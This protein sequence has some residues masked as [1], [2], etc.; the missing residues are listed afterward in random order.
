M[1]RDLKSLSDEELARIC[2]KMA[3]ENKLEIAGILASLAAVVLLFLAALAGAFALPFVVAVLT[4]LTVLGVHGLVGMPKRAY[5]EEL[6][7][8]RG[9]APLERYLEEARKELAQGRADWTILF[10]AHTSMRGRITW[11]RISLIEGPPAQAQAALRVSAWAL[12][13]K[14][15]EG[16]L[17]DMQVDG[18]LPDA[19]AQE[20]LTMLRELDLAALTDIAVAVKDGTHCGLAIVRPGA[21]GMGCCNLA[22]LTGEWRQLPTAIFSLKLDDI[23][24][25]FASALGGA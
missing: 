17:L 15:A 16:V 2:A 21:E 9:K 22:G 18:T 7:W 12:P 23:A 11:L 20:L 10:R 19:I 14:R 6:D 24:R 13:E 3:L 4:A 25:N 8:R 5:R 1:R